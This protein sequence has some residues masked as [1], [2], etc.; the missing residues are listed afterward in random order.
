M[1]LYDISTQYLATAN[2]LANMDIDDQT[3]AD[4]LE[5]EAKDT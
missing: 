4:T 1:N 2:Q 3:L 5:A